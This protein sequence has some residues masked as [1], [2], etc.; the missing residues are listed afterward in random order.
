M[1]GSIAVRPHT[2]TAGNLPA[3]DLDREDQV[4]ENQN[5][6]ELGRQLVLVVRQVQR[7]QCGTTERAPTKA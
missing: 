4:V 7:V 6:V 2:I 5:E 3:L 1:A